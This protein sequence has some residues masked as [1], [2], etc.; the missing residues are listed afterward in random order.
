MQESNISS[1]TLQS[2]THDELGE[3]ENLSQIKLFQFRIL[4]TAALIQ[5]KMEN[6]EDNQDPSALISRENAYLDDM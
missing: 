4:P 5:A 1:S 6:L 3:N 2:D